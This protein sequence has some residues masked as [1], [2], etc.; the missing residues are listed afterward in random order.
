MSTH[1][2]QLRATVI[3]RRVRCESQDLV[4]VGVVGKDREPEFRRRLSR[5]TID[6][7]GGVDQERRTDVDCKRARLIDVCR[8]KRRPQ[9]AAVVAAEGCEGQWI[10]G[11]EG[12]TGEATCD[13]NISIRRSDARSV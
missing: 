8:L 12:R 5:P 11:D 10:T 6:P 1:A 4:A 9:Y 7:T 3:G 2:Y 13:L